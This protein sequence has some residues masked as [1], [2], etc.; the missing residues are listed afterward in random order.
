MD[1]V[2]RLLDGMRRRLR[3]VWAASTGQWLAPVLAL[4]A[5]G[6]VVLGRVRPWG[7]PEPAALLAGVGA[8]VAV[9]VVAVVLRIPS[10]VAARAAD[11]GLLTRDAFATALE[12]AD[13]PGPL[14]ARVVARAESLAVGA[15]A[16]AAAP[17]RWAPRRLAFSGVL[18]VVAVTLAV[19]DNPQDEV[20]RRQAAERAAIAEE[21]RRLDEAADELAADAELGTRDAAVA[22]RLDELARELEQASSIEEAEVALEWA[23][24]ELAARVTPELLSQRAAVQGLS[25]SLAAN[26][27]PGASAE[28]A[29][30]EQ[31]EEAAAR[32]DG[33]NE[34]ELTAL[35]ERLEAVAAA[36][37]VANPELASALSAAS[38]ALSSG[39][40]GAA[41]AVLG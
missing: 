23:R 14:P 31:L 22:E 15:R 1:A 12:V 20:R 35:A 29:P 37:A 30:A 34:E 4:G 28:S 25:Q 39:D 27:L 19:V 2:T 3:L 36:Q 8:V 9:A 33:L 6:L 38:A 24:Q 41:R 13:R 40:V 10:A 16:A 17:L 11:R 7:W 18:T 5:L 32:L 26:P 21:A